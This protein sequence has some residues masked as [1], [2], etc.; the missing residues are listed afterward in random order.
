GEAPVPAG[1]V[2]LGRD[3]AQ[4]GHESRVGAQRVDEPRFRLAPERRAGDAEDGRGNVAPLDPGPSGRRGSPSRTT[5]GRWTRRTAGR[6]SWRSTRVPRV[7]PPG[8]ASRTSRGS[9]AR[10]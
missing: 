5:A 7:P 1:A 6:S 2:A 3:Q 4:L 9:R 10:A 8:D